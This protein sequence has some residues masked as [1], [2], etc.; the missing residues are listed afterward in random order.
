METADQEVRREKV[1]IPTD[2][3]TREI[4][5]KYGVSKSCAASAMKRGWNYSHSGFRPS[6]R[7]V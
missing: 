4:M 7:I 1:F 3:S 5:Q 2:M 6:F